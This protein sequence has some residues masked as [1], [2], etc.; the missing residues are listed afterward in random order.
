M[1][2]EAELK[3]LIRIGERMR[4]AQQAY[5]NGRNGDRRYTLL[6]LAKGWEQAFDAK[7]DYLKD[8]FIQPKLPF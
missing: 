6:S 4:K 2:H 7:L 1:N 5:F 3:E 8:N